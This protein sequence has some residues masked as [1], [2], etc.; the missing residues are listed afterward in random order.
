[1]CFTMGPYRLSSCL[2]KKKL[3]KAASM[4]SGCFLLSLTSSSLSLRLSRPLQT[5]VEFLL[6]QGGPVL[7]CTDI[8]SRLTLEDRQCNRCFPQTIA[9]QGVSGKNSSRKEN[10]GSGLSA[11]HLSPAHGFQ[12]RVCQVVGGHHNIPGVRGATP[13]KDRMDVG[14]GFLF[15]QRP[16]S[17]INKKLHI[18]HLHLGQGSQSVKMMVSFFTSAVSLS[19]QTPLL[20]LLFSCSVLSD[21]L[22]TPRTI[23]RQAPLSMEFSMA[24]I[25]VWV[26][27][28]FSGRSSQPRD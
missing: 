4:S 2:K 19:L 24:R 25:L 5:A 10:Q 12:D 23:V 7:A 16:V 15:F 8:I 26:V 1:M 20:L 22:A 11:T 21:S 6:S 27:I 13:G 18:R 14:T 28:S 17:Q 9:S 3:V